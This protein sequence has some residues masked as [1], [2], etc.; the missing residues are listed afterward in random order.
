MKINGRKITDYIA[1]LLKKEI[2]TLKKKKPLQLTTFLV[3]RENNQLSFIRIKSEVAKKLGIRFKLV[4]FKQTPSFETFVQRVKAASLDPDSG[5]IIIQQPLPAQL[6]TDS[7]YDYI[8]DVKE[9]EGHK[10]KSPFL[11][12]LGLAVLTVMKYIF[13]SQKLDRDLLISK[14]LDRRF[15]KKVFRNK[16]VVLVG[17]GLTGGKPIGKT[18]SEAKINYISIHS[19]TPNSV[20]YYRDADVIICAVGKKILTAEMLKTGVVL[21]NVGLRREQGK[22]KGDYEEKEIKNITSFYTPTPGGIG[23]LDVIY[24]YKNLIEAAKLQQ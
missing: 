8:A 17:R 13:G 10:R 16:K 11:P 21:I 18:L 19:K 22:L 7:V 1:K 5:G 24:L 2:R 23:P 3:G 4:H 20:S 9:I 12:P 6:A 14:E 15:F